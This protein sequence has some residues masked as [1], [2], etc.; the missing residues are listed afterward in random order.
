MLIQK[1]A[2]SPKNPDG[3]TI[4]H[5]I[6]IPL[7][8]GIV[9]SVAASL[10]PE[11]IADA[12]KDPRYII[13]DKKRLSEIT[14]PIMLDGKL[15]GIIDSEHSKKNFYTRRHLKR[16]EERRVGKECVSRCKNR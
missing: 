16:S 6:E 15:L 12:T 11:I 1:A 13:D 7:G 4:A 8:S 14:V 10:K 2:F 3:Y 5:A 9:G